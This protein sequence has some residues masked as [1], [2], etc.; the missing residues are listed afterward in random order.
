MIAIIEHSM[1]A[2][3]ASEARDKFAI[4]TG[5]KTADQVDEE[6]G[7]TYTVPNEAFVKNVIEETG[8]AQVL[9]SSGFTAD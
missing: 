8:F 5:V 1:T 9:A 6:L 7:R 3:R 2:K 4:S